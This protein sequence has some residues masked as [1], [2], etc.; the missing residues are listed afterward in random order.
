LQPYRSGRRF[1]GQA[2]GGLLA[3]LSV[4]AA[5]AAPAA[6]AVD[7]D[8]V[9]FRL[10]Q[11]KQTW[12]VPE[13]IDRIRLMAGGASGGDFHLP[14]VPAQDAQGGQGAEFDTEFA[15]TPGQSF[16]LI[17]GG[18]GDSMTSLSSTGGGG[19]GGGT[20]VATPTLA[21]AAGDINSLIVV[22]GGGGGAAGAAPGGA[23]GVDV[24][25]MPG[26]GTVVPGFGL[27]GQAGGGKADG[28]GGRIEDYTQPGLGIFVG[29][30]GGGALPNSDGLDNQAGPNDGNCGGGGLLGRGG[31]DANG[32][33]RG[34]GG[35]LLMSA[36]AG[37]SG[38]PARSAGGYG[39]GGCGGINIAPVRVPASGGTGGGGGGG[40]AG[41]AGGLDEL[42]GGGASSYLKPGLRSARVQAIGTNEGDGYVRICH[43]RVAGPSFV[44]DVPTMANWSKALLAMLLVT[45]GLAVGRAHQKR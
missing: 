45:L 4:G 18:E 31:D 1:V 14:G 13:G 32:S 21:S 3:V 17:V 20:V 12:R 27:V 41:G 11:L 44:A 22:A 39:G 10:T 35:A 5:Q 24:D 36:A 40:Y 25:G 2:L 33:I 26:A 15:V 42:S 29:N 19:G 43:A 37:V 30:G 7:Q 6:C 34:G 16:E 9:D 8:T 23:A 28:S 38:N